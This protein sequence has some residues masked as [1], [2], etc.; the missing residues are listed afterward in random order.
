MSDEV[1]TGCF[2]Q[3]LDSTDA[4]MYA[5][6]MQY[7]H[8]DENQD[9]TRPDALFMSRRQVKKHCDYKIPTS[10]IPAMKK[11]EHAV[12]QNHHHNRRASAQNVPEFCTDGSWIPCFQAGCHFW[13]HKGTGHCITND[14]VGF[15]CPFHQN[16][17]IC[18][19]N[20]DTKVDT[21]I[22]SIPFPSTFKF[23]EPEAQ[24]ST[25]YIKNSYFY[26]VYIES[27]H[28]KAPISHIVVRKSER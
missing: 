1:D 28:T 11:A 24:P 15:P 16:G 7:L 17:E 10:S 2:A 12:H 25:P 5:S 13:Q 9:R 27:R 6:R 3:P 26:I 22:D 21:E 8:S 19:W 14:V 20:G 18:V 23:L 4:M